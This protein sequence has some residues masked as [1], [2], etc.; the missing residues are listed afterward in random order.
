MPVTQSTFY[1][2][3]GNSLATLVVIIAAPVLGAMADQTRLCKRMLAIFAAF[4]MISCACLFLVEREFWPMALTLYVLA[5]VGFSSANIF[6]DS[7]IVSVS[8][9]QTRHRVSAFGY[10]MGYLGGG[11]LFLGCVVMTLQ[12]AWFGLEDASSAVRWSFINVSIWWA[13]FT[14]PLLLYVSEQPHSSVR[15][16]QGV[17]HG[18]VSPGTGIGTIV[19]QALGSATTTI[20][21]ISQHRNVWIF[22]VA[23]WFYID[24]VATIIRM[25]V[26]YGLSIGLSAN[27]LISALLMVQFI[28]FPATLLFGRVAEKIGVKR[29]LWIALTAYVIATMYAGF[30]KT[31]TEFYV[32][33]AVLGLVQ[34]AVQSLSRSFYSQII[35]PDKVGEYFGY[36]NMIGKTAAFV[37]P[38]M[39]GTV[40]YM[41]GSSRLGLLSILVLFVIGM[42]VLRFVEDTPATA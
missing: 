15:E 16:R 30:M 28:G 3:L 8:S 20:K 24:G 6:Y 38:V 7:L 19:R 32:L 12:P 14:I 37:G 10:A 26:D 9:L 35:P 41:T 33:A 29:G 39:V 22:L 4:G 17:S 27:S 2:G 1:L 42:L 31:S 40:A 23:Y 11:I 36:Q 25:G 5:V 21:S 18:T 34:G 13:V